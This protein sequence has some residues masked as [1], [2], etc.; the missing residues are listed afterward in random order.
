VDICDE[1]SE[2]GTTEHVGRGLGN[3]RVVVEDV[4]CKYCRN[5]DRE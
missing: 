4:K 1:A 2:D 5:K 3:P